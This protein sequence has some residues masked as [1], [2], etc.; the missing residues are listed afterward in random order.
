MYLI[1]TKIILIRKGKLND[2]DNWWN[3]GF[4]KYFR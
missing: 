1:D 2:L 4:Q 3:K